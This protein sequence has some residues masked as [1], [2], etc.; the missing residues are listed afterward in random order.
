MSKTRNIAFRGFTLIELMIVVAI[1][2]ILAAVAIPAFMKYIRRSKTA[3][4][5]GNLRKIYDGVVAYMNVEHV[6]SIGTILPRAFPANQVQ[7]PA[8]ATQCSNAGGKYPSNS[9]AWTTTS[10][11]DINFEIND[12][13]YYDYGFTSTNTTTNVSSGNTMSINAQGNLN[14]AGTTSLF[15]RIAQVDSTSAVT[16]SGVAITSELE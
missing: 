8:S 7:T 3:E 2:G 12:P 16:S 14:C 1:I 9:S 6:S 5:N 4:A 11:S 10:W 15:R 13:H